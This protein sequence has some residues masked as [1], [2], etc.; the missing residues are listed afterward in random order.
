[1]DADPIS[2]A[3]RRRRR[4]DRLGPN[5]VCYF[6]GYSNP[7]ALMRC[8]RSLLERDHIYGRKRDSESIIVIC[9]NCHAEITEDRMRE[10]V[11]MRRERD[12]QMLIAYRLLA[13][14][15]FQQKDAVS[16]RDMALQ[17]LGDEND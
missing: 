14:S 1:V 6:C 17:L 5:S 4:L 15:I 16:M 2:T 3:H 9:R 11:P 12:P 7:I 8:S 10:G 13:R